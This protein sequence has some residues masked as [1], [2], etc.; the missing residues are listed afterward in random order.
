MEVA[1]AGVMLSLLTVSPNMMPSTGGWPGKSPWLIMLATINSFMYRTIQFESGYPEL[2]DNCKSVL[3][4]C[5]ENFLVSG[6]TF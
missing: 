1:A 5:E 2:Q 3:R 6:I 4:N